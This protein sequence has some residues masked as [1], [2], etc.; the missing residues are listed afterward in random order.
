MKINNV[1]NT[2]VYILV[3]IPKFTITKRTS[4]KTLL[5]LIRFENDSNYKFVVNEN[6]VQ[7]NKKKYEMY[8]NINAPKMQIKF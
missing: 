7:Y 1:Q 6:E 3:S 2:R 4:L 5:E 8:I